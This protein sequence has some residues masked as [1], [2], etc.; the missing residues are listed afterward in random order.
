MIGHVKV[1][2][3]CDTI[4]VIVSISLFFF[5]F[6][7]RVPVNSQMLVFAKQETELV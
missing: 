5:D 4:H 1:T 7:K 2:L 6:L 3:Q